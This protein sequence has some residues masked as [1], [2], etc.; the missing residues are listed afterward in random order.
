MYSRPTPLPPF[1]FLMIRRPPRST[2]FPYT[3]LFRSRIPADP[4]APYTTVTHWWGSK[5]EFRGRTINEEKHVAFAEY[6]ELPTR[7]SARLELAVCLAE[8]YENY[9][10]QMEPAGW[11]LREAW[12]GSATPED[13]RA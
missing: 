4:T 10:R 1:F 5:F 11:R 7:T 2:L 9:R 8:H 6:K 13:Y 3:T 12:E